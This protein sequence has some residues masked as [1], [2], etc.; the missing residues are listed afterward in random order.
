MPSGPSSCLSAAIGQIRGTIRP[1]T[2]LAVSLALISGTTPVG[3]APSRG[4]LHLGPTGQIRATGAS[5]IAFAAGDFSDIFVIDS[6][7]GGRSRLTSGR[8]TDVAPAWSSDGRRIAFERDG[9][10]FK[11]RADGSRVRRLTRGSSYDTGPSWSP[12]GRWITFSRERNGNTDIHKMRSDGSNTQRLTRNPAV[13]FAPA[14]SPTGN[15]IAFASNRGDGTFRIHTVRPNGRGTRQVTER[16]SGEPSW[17]PDGSEIAFA[18][19]ADGDPEIYVMR[20]DGSRMRRLTDNEAQDFPPSWS[21]DGRRIV[22]SSDRRGNFDLYS[23][24]RDGT[25]V[26]RLTRTR[27]HETEPAWRPG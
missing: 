4:R 20:A 21:P 8:A 16:R 26:R 25:G 23:I 17:S 11:M 3:P 7:G 15:R 9:D 6:D 22:F 24:R 19:A 1:F 12:D 27:V 2:L 5:Q 14:W 18:S 13:D 10:I